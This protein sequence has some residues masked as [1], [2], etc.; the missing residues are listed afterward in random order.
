[1]ML[2]LVHN[3]DLN[4]G[5]LHSVSLT[6]SSQFPSESQGE[7]IRHSTKHNGWPGHLVR[8]V[9][10]F[11]RNKEILS[12][13][14]GSNQQSLHPFSPFLSSLSLLC[15]S[16]SDRFAQTN[17]VLK[18]RL[19]VLKDFLVHLTLLD[20]TLKWQILNCQH[21]LLWDLLTLNWS[22]VCGI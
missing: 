12:N 6:L 4:E 5:E 18:Q 9:V 20:S 19:P 15:D 10:L 14:S 22:R 8:L 1:M 11:I 7:T 16:F 17:C 3:F 2:R 13:S 21:C